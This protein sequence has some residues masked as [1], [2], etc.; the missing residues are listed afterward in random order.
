MTGQATRS[1][2]KLWHFLKKIHLLSTFGDCGPTVCE[3]TNICQRYLIMLQYHVSTWVKLSQFGAHQMENHKRFHICSYEDKI[4]NTLKRIGIKILEQRGNKNWGRPRDHKSVQRR[5]AKG[6][7]GAY[8]VA[9]N[10]TN[11]TESEITKWG[12]LIGDWDR[13]YK[14]G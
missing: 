13:D 9:E 7:L 1:W 2:H 14:V 8:K 10:V 5:N 11:W 6:R 12:K 4:L 3:K